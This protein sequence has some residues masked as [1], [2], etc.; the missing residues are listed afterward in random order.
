MRLNE[1]SKKKAQF[2]NRTL[3][4]KG[5]SKYFESALF[6]N[7]L[8]KKGKDKYWKSPFGSF[9]NFKRVVKKEGLKKYEPYLKREKLFYLRVINKIPSK[10]IIK[11]V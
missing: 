6:Q 10:E 9:E 4:V 5:S 11:I 7:R 3:F 2:N 1:W 8:G